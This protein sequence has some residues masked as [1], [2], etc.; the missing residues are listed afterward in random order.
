M[1]AKLSSWRLKAQAVQF[2]YVAGEKGCI[3]P[4]CARGRRPPACLATLG[5][6]TGGAATRNG[7]A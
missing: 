4:F 1:R 6:A 3:R 2:A 7:S 5:R